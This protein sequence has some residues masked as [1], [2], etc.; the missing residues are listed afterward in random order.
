MITNHCL[1]STMSQYR[2]VGLIDFDEYLA[3]RVAQTPSLRPFFD[4]YR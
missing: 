3:P 4:L 1:Y 2:W